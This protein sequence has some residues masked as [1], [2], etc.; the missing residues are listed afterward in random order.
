MLNG[1]I[2]TSS[3]RS[4][5]HGCSVIMSRR[6]VITGTDRNVIQERVW[7]NG[8]LLFSGHLTAGDGQNF[9]SRDTVWTALSLFRVDSLFKRF[10]QIKSSEL[11]LVKTTSLTC[12]R[13]SEPLNQLTWNPAQTPSNNVNVGNDGDIETNG[14]IFPQL[15]E[16]PE[17]DGGRWV[18]GVTETFLVTFTKVNVYRG[19]SVIP[20]ISEKPTTVE[21]T[22]LEVERSIVL[23]CLNEERPNEGS[24]IIN[25]RGRKTIDSFY[26]SHTK[27]ANGFGVAVSI[28][29]QHNRSKR[30]KWCNTPQNSILHL[31]TD[32]VIKLIHVS[33]GILLPKVTKSNFRTASVN[34][35][36]TPSLFLIV[37][38]C[39]RPAVAKVNG[40]H[41]NPVCPVSPKINENGTEGV[42]IHIK[43]PIL[44]LRKNV[45]INLWIKLKS[46]PM[47]V[48]NEDQ[49][50]DET[51]KRLHSPRKHGV[52]VCLILITS[53]SFPSLPI[54]AR[55]VMEIQGV[56]PTENWSPFKAIQNT[57]EMH[58]SVSSEYETRVAFTLLPTLILNIIPRAGS[59]FLLI[60]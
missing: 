7:G 56:N 8:P 24:V 26:L 3:L 40:E 14:W 47:S 29:V 54:V 51:S 32:D 38:Q 37:Y 30:F 39:N 2:K 9:A 28:I 19:T 44:V 35:E 31:G 5:S 25:Y 53:Q 34:T 23:S 43:V 55:N 20:E 33:N 52:T 41:Q 59:E 15:Q 50:T 4:C 12:G 6:M 57:V 45:P 42:C 60:P 49:R 48:V 18:A 13:R 22:S 46:L 17:R 58:L 11:R 10:S 16:I 21:E 1:G 36:S 27:F